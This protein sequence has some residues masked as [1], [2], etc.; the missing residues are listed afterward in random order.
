MNKK[1]NIGLLLALFSGAASADGIAA[2]T[3]NPIASLIV[4]IGYLVGLTLFVHGLY[5]IKKNSE[6]P[7]Q[8][9]FGKCVA[10][11]VSGVLLLLSGYFYGVVRNSAVNDGWSY[12]NSNALALDHTALSNMGD[13][14]QSFLG[15]YLPVQTIEMLIGFVYLFGLMSFL[16]GIYMLKSIGAVNNQDGIGKVATHICG[17]IVC[18]N[19]ASFSCLVSSFIGVSMLCLGS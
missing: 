7:Q 4:S 8:Y 17:G 16:K 13:L 15:Q 5:G 1:I 10:E 14:S 3:I 12:D 9:P 11:M 6:S 19:I 2:E 18:M